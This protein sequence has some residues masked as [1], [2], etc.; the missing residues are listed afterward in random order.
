MGLSARHDGGDYAS[1]IA[2][3]LPSGAAWDFADDGIF[4]ALISALADEMDR[5]DGRICD[6]VREA[7]PRT[8]LELLPDWE[9]MA[10][11]PDECFG[12]ADSIAE[13]QIAAAQKITGQ[14]GQ[15]RPFFIALAA[16]L[17]YVVEIEE[18]APFTAGC[19]AGEDLNSE[20]WR[21]VWRMNILPPEADIPAEQFLLSQF[22]AGSAA[23]E[24]LRGFGALDLECIIRRAAH[25]HII[26][27]FSY[28]IEPEPIFWIDF[29]AS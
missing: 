26:V 8:A 6:L 11:L 1:Q 19:R 24:R 22:T 5:I 15:S 3:L 18:F 2:A 28:P 9:R 4:A 20:D 16:Q 27:L 23:G 13:R 10:G 14:G 29:T 12:A 21:F 7:D 17:G 25:A